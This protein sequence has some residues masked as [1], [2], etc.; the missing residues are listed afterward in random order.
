MADRRQCDAR[1]R[2]S[3][4]SCE[5]RQK[6]ARELFGCGTA[7]SMEEVVF[8][9][10]SDGRANCNAALAE[11]VIG[12]QIIDPYCE[13]IDVVGRVTDAE[14]VELGHRMAKGEFGM[15]QMVDVVSMLFVYLCEICEV[16]LVVIR[17]LQP[18]NHLGDAAAR[19]LGEGLKWNTSLR[20]LGLVSCGFS[21]LT[22]ACVCP[23]FVQK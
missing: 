3:G 18:F 6:I 5:Q 15:V 4:R 23:E 11:L 1:L 17:G 9:G 8:R 14:V 22:I 21:V 7:E 16:L 19:S 12:G 13:Q 10:E 20:H 2:K